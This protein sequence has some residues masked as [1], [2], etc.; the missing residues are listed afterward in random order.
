[1]GPNAWDSFLSQ[2]IG[3]APFSRES[4]CCNYPIKILKIK[5]VKI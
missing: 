3:F 1:M 4:T 2:A 5:K